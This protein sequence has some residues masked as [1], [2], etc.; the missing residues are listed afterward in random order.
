[1]REPEPGT[2]LHV[3]AV[4]RE[5]LPRGK[6]EAIDV[7]IRV[8][9]MHQLAAKHNARREGPLD[10]MRLG[11]LYVEAN[12]WPIERTVAAIAQP[13]ALTNVVA[14][15][16]AEAQLIVLSAGESR[17]GEAGGEETDP[18]H[19]AHYA[20]RD[21]INRMA[22]RYAELHP[23]DLGELIRNGAPAILPWGA[24]EWHGSHLPLG[25]D[26]IVAEAF[27]ERLADRLSGVLLP[28]IWLPITTLPH[29][30][31][32]EVGTQALRSIASETLSGLQRAGFERVAIIT[33]HYAQ[34]HL[35]ELYEI[36]RQ[37]PLPT[38]VGTPLEPL[39]DDSLLDHAAAVETAQLMALRPE[40]VRIDALPTIP[41]V[42]ENAVLGK[43]PRTGTASQ[44]EE[45]FVRAIDA[46][47]A[48]MKE[49]EPAL[50]EH[51]LARQQSLDGYKQRFFR[52]SWQQAIQDWWRERSG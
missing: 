19:Q 7:A 10:A 17:N 4:T 34:G 22:H 21:T 14:E 27:A 29:P 18:C 16:K 45:L 32:L 6:E 48:W 51:Y 42:R 47:A 40:L 13:K 31:S 26:G 15:V 28:G 23:Q 20:E 33:G 35:W 37:A 38:F 36:A 41:T 8:A 39:S 46:W 43:D 2:R 50:A 52:E 30:Y 5:V 9:A 11:D 44:G 3:E 25:L 24:L 49:V 1:M 12:R